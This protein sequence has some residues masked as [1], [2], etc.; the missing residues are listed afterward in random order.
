MPFFIWKESFNTHIP[1]VDRQHQKIFAIMNRLF[2]AAQAPVDHN[3]VMQSLREMNEYSNLHFTTEEKLMAHYGYQELET[4]KNQHKYYR[5]QM[6][7]QLTRAFH[8]E[9]EKVCKDSLQFLRDWFLNHILQEDLKFAEVAA[10]RNEQPRR[11]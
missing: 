4:Q 6:V 8:E 9:D 10:Q 11:S 2:D 7:V 3:H 1:V 5:E